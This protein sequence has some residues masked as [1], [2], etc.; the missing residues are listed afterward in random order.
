MLY[1]SERNYGCSFL[2]V[3]L[4][5]IRTIILENE[6]IRITFLLDVGTEIIEFNHKETDTD[7]IQRSPLV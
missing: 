5:G 1:T 7:F 3:S 2:E 4:L 6:K